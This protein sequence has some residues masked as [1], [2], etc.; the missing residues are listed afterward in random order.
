MT[1]ANATGSQRNGSALTAE[2]MAG[3]VNN[4]F[5]EEIFTARRW[6]WVEQDD[7]PSNAAWRRDGIS[8]MFGGS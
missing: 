3:L 8:E 1:P 6:R 4:K 5:R 2:E 7:F